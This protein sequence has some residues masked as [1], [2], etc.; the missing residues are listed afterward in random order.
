MKR[1]KLLTFLLVGVNLLSLASCDKNNEHIHE[2]NDAWSHDENYHY[3]K[4]TCGHDEIS[5]KSYHLFSDWEVTLNPTEDNEGTKERRCLICSYVEIKDV[6]KLPHT[7]KFSESWDSNSTH[8]WHSSTCGDNVVDQFALHS[9]SDWVVTLNPTED[10]TGVKERKCS[11][12]DYIERGLVDK[13]PHTHKFSTNYSYDKEHHYYESI[14]DHDVISEKEKHNFSS[15]V[16]IS[17]PTIDYEGEKHRT[18][19]ICGYVDVG[20]IEKIPHEHRYSSAWTTTDEY[21]WHASSGCGCNNLKG[22]YGKHEYSSSIWIIEKTPTED[23]EGL[24]YKICDVCKYKH[25]EKIDKLP[26]THKF[27]ENYEYDDKDHWHA[28]TCGHDE[29]I[30]KEGHS[31]SDWYVVKEST[32]EEEGT[33][34]RKCEI[35]D[36]KE[37]EN[38]PLHVH[39]FSSEWSHNESQHWHASTCGHDEIISEI[40][41]HTFI[42]GVCLICNMIQPIDF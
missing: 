21:H 3:H 19:S 35:C 22:N 23:E 4:A 31:F 11:V 13:L 5:D 34:E 37:T 30:T 39:T 29:T 28:S 26:H 8:H 18:C 33:K 25:Y 2:F 10:E 24:V 41:N 32:T 27:S 6:D 20:V 36:Y 15:W 1:S 12:C 40:E 7:H 9:F 42:N 14:C 17:E 38:L 16:T